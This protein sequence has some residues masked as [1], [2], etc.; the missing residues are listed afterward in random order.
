[1]SIVL[2]VSRRPG[3]QRS[4]E[5][6]PQARSATQPDRSVHGGC[7]FKSQQQATSFCR[8]RQLPQGGAPNEERRFAAP[9][10]T[11]FADARAKEERAVEQGEQQIGATPAYRS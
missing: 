4:G 3:R 9:P 1:M 10:M 11:S 6:G 8:W 5:M 2:F 7:W